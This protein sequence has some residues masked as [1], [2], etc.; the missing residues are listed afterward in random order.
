MACSPDG[1]ECPRH[2]PAPALPVRLHGRCRVA[3]RCKGKSNPRAGKRVGEKIPSQMSSI[4]PACASA[5]HCGLAYPLAVQT[6][7]LLPAPA[8]LPG[9][10]IHGP[11]QNGP[12]ML[13][14]GI[15][16]PPK[17][18]LTLSPSDLR[19]PRKPPATSLALS[20]D[21][22]VS[23]KTIRDIWN[24]CVFPVGPRNLRRGPPTA[25]P[26]LS[27]KKKRGGKREGG[28]GV[29]GACPSSRIPAP[30]APR[31]MTLR[32]RRRFYDCARDSGW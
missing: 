3:R 5:P 10:W 1:R 31:G 20:S 27:G 25:A 11:G 9:R 29:D 30:F 21:Y 2:L 12:N 13:C 7:L 6:G 8:L 19:P 17:K 23:V 32:A 14:K 28:G 18:T 22:G 16:W 15:R 26:T 4:H 24:R